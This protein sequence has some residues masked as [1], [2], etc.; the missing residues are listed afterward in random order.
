MSAV[1]AYGRAIAVVDGAAQPITTVA[2]VHVA[3]RPLVFVPL[4]LAGEANAPLAAMV[5]TDPSAPRLLIVPQPRDR[6]LRFGF[7]A[8][9]ADVVLAYLD[10]FP[11]AEGEEPTAEDAPQ[12]WVPNAAGL[13]FLRLFGRSTRFRR[14]TGQ[15][16]V[17]PGVPVLG[18]WLT[19]FAER[20]EYPGASTLLAATEV[21]AAH[22]ATGQSALE[23]ANL[24]ALLGWI[25]PPPGRSPREAARDAEDPLLS[26]P[27]GPSTDPS[28]DN[29][30]L[31][32]AIAAYGA[33]PDGSAVQERARTNLENALRSQTRP[34]WDL[35]WRA[36][37]LLRGLT[38]GA[39]VAGRWAVDRRRFAGFHQWLAE[40]G[41]PQAR[42]DGAVAAARRL[43]ALEWAQ[44]E[45]TVSR[46][47]DDP[48]V[49]ADFRVTGEAFRGTVVE[50]DPERRV[51]NENG[52][53]VKR[54]RVV[55]RTEDPV[56]LAPGTAV[57]SPVRPKQFG[58]ILEI[59]DGLVTLELDKGIRPAKGG[60]VLDVL[61]R[62]GDE[63]T[64]TSVLSS[65][66]RGP[67][68]PSPEDTPWTHGGPPEPYVPTDEDAVEAWE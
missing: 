14:T 17:A 16:P 1:S 10:E 21:L 49:M 23:D 56:Q 39:S 30:I 66:N 2:H 29:E 28:F 20:S 42:R 5:G 60:S 61:P 25:D 67:A 15:Y 3:A 6:G 48:L 58:R 68:L 35:I 13:G 54:P 22:W 7:A 63:L 38:P 24:A 53:L 51:E 27:A 55:V 62:V 40:D 34:T 11:V 36:I 65:G 59:T 9:L 37:E 47:F 31:A 18:R 8:E 44:H 12:I 52:N 46:S 32:P 45:Y 19:W 33:A 50:L 57:G 64:Y 26:P 41:P 43:L 4:A